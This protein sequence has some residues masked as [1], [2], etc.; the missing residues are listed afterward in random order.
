MLWMT[1]SSGHGTQ[2]AG[3]PGTDTGTAREMIWFGSGTFRAVNGRIVWWT[4]SIVPRRKWVIGGS[5]GKPGLAAGATNVFHFVITSDKPITT[6][7]LTAKISVNRIVLEGNK[8]ADAVKDVQIQDP[9][10]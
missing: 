2:I 7:N 3:R 8:L 10:K 6:T 9:G 4:S 5:E 1:R